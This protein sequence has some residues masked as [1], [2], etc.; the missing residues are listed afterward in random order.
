MPSQSNID[1][2]GALHHIIV[3]GFARRKFFLTIRIWIVFWFALGQFYAAVIRSAYYGVF[4]GRPVD[5]RRHDRAFAS[6]GIE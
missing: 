6:K 1:A 3:R 4:G 2:P 5:A